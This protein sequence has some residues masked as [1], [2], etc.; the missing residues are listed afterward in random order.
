MKRNKPLQLPKKAT[1]KNWWNG[2]VTLKYA[3]RMIIEDEEPHLV[4]WSDFS[5]TNV[6]KIRKKQK[7]LFEEQ[8]NKR[9]EALQEHFTRSHEA[10]EMKAEH[11]KN[12]IGQCE[13]ILYGKLITYDDILLKNWGVAF[14]SKY[15]LDIQNY[16]QRTVFQGFDDGLDFIHSP[17]C[18]YQDQNTTDARIYARAIW[19]YYKWLE[20]HGNEQ[21]EIG[22]ASMEINTRA[23]WFKVALLFAKGQIDNLQKGDVNYTKMATIL[24]NKSYRPY[25]SESVSNATK[26][27]KNIFSRVDDMQSFLHYCKQNNI[28]VV[29]SFHKRVRAGQKP[30]D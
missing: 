3:T 10:S 6:S 19:N 29:D 14:D 12:E 22:Q 9:L 5:A 18:K 30:S 20:S 25:I 16:I 28:E 1:Y 13:Y 27:D 2:D 26:S 17:N 7:E 8:V 4:D 23:L 15:E 21:Q 11:F 24:G